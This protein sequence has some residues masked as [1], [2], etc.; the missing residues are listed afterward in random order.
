MVKRSLYL[1]DDLK[2]IVLKTIQRN[3]YFAHPE[4]ILLAMLQ[5]DASQI[6]ELALR[7]VLDARKGTPTEKV[8]E[9]C[10]PELQVNATNYYDL[11][12]WV[13][14]KVTEPPM[15]MKYTDAEI[16]KLICSEN[17]FLEFENFPCHTQAVERCVKLVTEASISVCGSEA[18]DGFIRSRIKARQDIPLFETKS[19][20][21]QQWN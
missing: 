20:F 10:I 1:R 12:D 7:R 6:R 5:D 4:N 16:S 11:I 18:R 8:R 21:F 19:Q 15:T 13:N 17:N 9:F 2:S 14:V 3:S